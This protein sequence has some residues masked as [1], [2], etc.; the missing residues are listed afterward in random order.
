M[1]VASIRD[2]TRLR[3]D[4]KPVKITDLGLMEHVADA[5]EPV[6]STG[7]WSRTLRRLGVSVAPIS[8]RFVRKIERERIVEVYGTL[9]MSRQL[10]HSLSKSEGVHG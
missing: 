7:L 2:R 4:G 8:W 10:W 3:W 5:I 1:M 6:Y 9:F